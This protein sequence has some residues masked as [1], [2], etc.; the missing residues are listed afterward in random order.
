[1]DFASYEKNKSEGNPFCFQK[2]EIKQ[3]DCGS[4]TI[5]ELVYLTNNEELPLV[6]L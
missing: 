4:N 6:R 5:R 3:V 1:M 2:S